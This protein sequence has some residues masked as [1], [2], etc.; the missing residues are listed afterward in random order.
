MPL[1]GSVTL[2]RKPLRHLA[3]LINRKMFVSQKPRKTCSRRC[4]S[5]EWRGTSRELR[6]R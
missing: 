6:S 5:S 2:E 3:T 1:T 4:E